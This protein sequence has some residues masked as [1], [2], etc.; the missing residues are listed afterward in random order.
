MLS[1]NPQAVVHAMRGQA[2]AI[3]RAAFVFDRMPFG[4]IVGAEIGVFT[5][6]VSK[7]L[8]GYPA[9]SLYMVDSWEGDGA[10][11][12]SGNDWHAGLTQEQQDHFA[13]VAA[14]NTEFA[15]DRRTIVRKRSL[16]AAKDIADK[17]LDFV[18]LDADHSEA[19]LMADIDA[20]FP[21]VHQGGILCGH[22]Y[23]NPLFP[24]VRT[25]VGRVFGVV[26]A[27]ENLM[28]WA[29]TC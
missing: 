23:G 26:D 10:A 9:L 3:L 24:D 4:Q 17:S 21:K 19:G 15:K 11:Y 18:F 6:R 2:D 25:V 7:A 28:M 12:E 16:D 1:G 27:D 20:W 8:L 22:D 29:V 14:S 13:R 5:G